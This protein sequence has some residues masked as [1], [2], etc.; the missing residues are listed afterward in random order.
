[1][2]NAMCELGP[3]IGFG[4]ATSTDYASGRCA[5][6][7]Q[8][9]RQHQNPRDGSAVLTDISRFSW[10]VSQKMGLSGPD[11]EKSTY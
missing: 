8:L 5:Q 1:M 11:M 6:Q 4:Y 10:G 9:K 7:R 2:L 3:I